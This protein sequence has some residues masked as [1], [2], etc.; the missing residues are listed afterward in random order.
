MTRSKCS[1]GKP[2]AAKVPAKSKVPKSSSASSSSK[3]AKGSSKKDQIFLYICQQHAMGMT[4][5]NK[6]DVSLAVGNKN[7]RSEGFANALRELMNVDRTVGTADSGGKKDR[8]R[9]TERG[10]ASI[11]AGME[12]TTDPTRVHER[13]IEF[14]QQKVKLGADKVRSF[15]EILQQD[16]TQPRSVKDIATK[17]GYNNPRSFGNTK[18]VAVTKELGLV[19]DAGKGLVQFTDKVPK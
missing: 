19:E 14:V 3:T 6:L 15:W 13:Y 12:M 4:E 17:L 5:V 8:L 2:K 7:P 11:P 9:L 18:I 10:I 1:A 16:R